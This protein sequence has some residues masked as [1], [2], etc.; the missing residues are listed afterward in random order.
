MRLALALLIAVALDRAFG[1]PP[2]AIHPV[3]WMGSAIGW[4][5]DWALRRSRVDQFVRG[6]IVAL[7]V[8]VLCA[9]LAFCVARVAARCS[10]VSVLATALLLKPLFAIRAL[11]EAAF[12]VRD[13]VTAGDIDL[14]RTQLSSL[15]SRDAADLDPAA[16]IA[17]TVESIAENASDS[18]VAPFFYFGLGGL[19]GAAFYRAG[20]T[21]DAM[22]GYH[23]RYEWVGKTAAR[24]DDLLNLLPARLTSLLFL[25]VAPLSGGNVRRG[26]A[27]LWR[28][29]GR[30]ESPNAGRPMAAMAG[31]LGI[32][33]EKLGHYRLGDATRP[34]EATDITRAWRIV[35]GSAYAS[36]ILTAASLLLGVNTAA[37]L[38]AWRP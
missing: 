30:T 7:T 34:I 5:R 1:E 25:L 17:A 14:A 12:L 10:L 11:R 24:L 33:L 31:L 22:I 19:P 28:D 4:G 3:A 2:N 6:A 21:L 36:A 8:P 23:G 35:S 9:A 29:G 38:T 37:W 18:I 27:T 26:A 15:C 20:N 32:R 16:L 13:A